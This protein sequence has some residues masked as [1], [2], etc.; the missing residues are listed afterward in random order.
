MNELPAYME[1]AWEELIDG[2]VVLMSPRPSFNHNVVAENIFFLFK[3]ALRGKPCRPIADGT[4][5]YL[6]EKERY[7]PD[8][9][10]VC[11]R[12]KLKGNGVHG[13]PDLVVEVLSPGTAKNDRGHKKKAYEQHGVK[14]YWIVNPADRTLEQYLLED[15][16][17]EL[18]EVYAIHPDYMLEKMTPEERAA[19]KTEVVCGLSD[20]LVLPLVDIFGDLI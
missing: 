15:G 17:L 14:E 20:A 8:G 16:T 1:E 4:D 11:E 5:L 2:K 19:I 10:I 7:V 9:M 6:S 12:S 3:Q 18:H 13:A